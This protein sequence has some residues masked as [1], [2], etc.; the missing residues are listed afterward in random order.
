MRPID[1]RTFLAGLTSSLVASVG[2]FPALARG[3]QQY[4]P[5][6]ETKNPESCWLDVCA[7]FVV[8]DP[9]LGLSTEL[10]LTAACFPGVDGFRDAQFA[11][12]YDVALFDT[13]GREIPMTSS[14]LVVPAMRP[15]VLRMGELA[16]RKQF[17]G[18]AKVRLIPRGENVTRAGDLFSAG[19]MRWKSA[20]NLDN[21][22][23]H[24]ASCPSRAPE[25]SDPSR[26][27]CW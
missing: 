23:A 16:R 4:L 22:H 3:A 7:P 27:R 18:S 26:S 11:T 5:A 9:D 2:A 12:E 13:S 20:Q 15:T 14:R 17:W 6:P 1:R 8:E 10:L 19:F 21:V 24:P 25:C